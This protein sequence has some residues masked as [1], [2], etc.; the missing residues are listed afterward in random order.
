MEWLF[1]ASITGTVNDVVK[2]TIGELDESGDRW[3][4]SELTCNAE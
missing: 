1:A 4:P 3:N 2:V